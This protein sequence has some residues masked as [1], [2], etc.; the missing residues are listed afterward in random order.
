M[1][2]AADDTPTTPE[3]G[4]PERADATEVRPWTVHEVEVDVVRPL[5][6]KYL[7]PGSDESEVHYKT[8]EDATARHFAAMDENDQVVGVGSMHVE[9]RVAGIAPYGIP[10]MRIRGMAVE[11]AWRGHGVGADI[12]R[13]IVAAGCEAGIQEVWANARTSNLGFYQRTRFKPVSSSFEIPK[14]G[15]HVVMA[16]GLGKEAKKISKQAKADEDASSEDAGTE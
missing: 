4:S 9:N 7:R 11:E 14:I 3:S 1:T 16:R 10:G 2:A 13:A 5:R 6:L 15:E 12:I 8:D